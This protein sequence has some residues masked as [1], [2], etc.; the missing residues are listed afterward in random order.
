MRIELAGK[1]RISSRVR[2]AVI[3]PDGQMEVFEGKVI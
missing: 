2:A 3:G 1:T